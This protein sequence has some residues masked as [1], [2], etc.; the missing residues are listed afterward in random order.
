MT[1]SAITK[2]I[3]NRIERLNERYN[4]L[5]MKI[6]YCKM[7]GTD[8]EFD[9]LISK[10]NRISMERSKLEDMLRVVRKSF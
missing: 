7:Y 10:R 3:E 5:Q 1:L 9:E 2:E 6:S 8:K 4:D